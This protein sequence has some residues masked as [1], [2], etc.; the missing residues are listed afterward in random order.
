MGRYNANQEPNFG[1]RI[2]GALL[3]GV[4]GITALSLV[5]AGLK[6]LWLRF[7]T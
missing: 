3:L 6:W 5:F 7:I 4:L 1:D 2:I